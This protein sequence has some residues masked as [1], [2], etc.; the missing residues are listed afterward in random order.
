MRQWSYNEKVEKIQK[1]KTKKESKSIKNIF[2]F[3]IFLII[4]LIILPS[5]EAI[6][7]K[8]LYS[9]EIT[10]DYETTTISFDNKDLLTLDV[11]NVKNRLFTFY[12]AEFTLAQIKQ[13]DKD[14]ILRFLKNSTFTFKGSVAIYDFKEKGQTPSICY[15]TVTGIDGKVLLKEN[16]DIG[17]N[18][19]S[20]SLKKNDLDSHS[21]INVTI[22]NSK[23]I[24]YKLRFLPSKN[25]GNAK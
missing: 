24:Q 9:Y 21:K 10:N 1:N 7:W 11:N 16:L 12:N 25:L 20:I 14:I 22:S 3:L 18:L 5:Q 13:K 4:L 15:I 2:K 17:E 8:I 6:K 23:V 19:I